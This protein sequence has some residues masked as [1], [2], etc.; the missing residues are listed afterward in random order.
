MN[1]KKFSDSVHQVDVIAQISLFSS[2][3]QTSQ[4]SA[5]PAE[6]SVSTSQMYIA[7]RMGGRLTDQSHPLEKIKTPCICVI[8]AKDKN[9]VKLFIC[10]A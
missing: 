2:I 7:G 8:R 10:V 6:V 5:F 4:V 3:V 9:I 1:I